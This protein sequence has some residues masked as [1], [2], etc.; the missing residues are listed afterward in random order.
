MNGEQESTKY[1]AFLDVAQKKCFERVTDTLKAE[2]IQCEIE[3]LKSEQ[4]V[5]VKKCKGKKVNSTK[6]QRFQ[7]GILRN[8]LKAYINRLVKLPRR[9]IRFWKILS[10][11]QTQAKI[12]WKRVVSKRQR[13]FQQLQGTWYQPQEGIQ[14]AVLNDSKI[15][16]KEH[17]IVTKIKGNDRKSESDSPS[18]TTKKATVEQKVEETSER[19]GTRAKGGSN[20]YKDKRLKRA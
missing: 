4:L 5:E 10:L 7:R 12:R 18:V 15:T 11:W 14:P 20:N 2:A 19:V 13:I 17:D 8:E 16:V 3:A 6:R 1:S 9:I